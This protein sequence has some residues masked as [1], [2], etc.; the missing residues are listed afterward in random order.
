MEKSGEKILNKMFQEPVE[1]LARYLERQV[2]QEATLLSN[3]M[4]ACC[5]LFIQKM[6]KARDFEEQKDRSI[7]SV[8][9]KTQQNQTEGSEHSKHKG[10]AKEALQEEHL[11]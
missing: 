6:S 2:Y 8:F 7:Q 3:L 1:R 11:N 4:N 5:L 10:T 9:S